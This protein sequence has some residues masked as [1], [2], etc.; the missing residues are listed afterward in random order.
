MP[1]PSSGHRWSQID[2]A[3]KTHQVVRQWCLDWI[4]REASRQHNAPTTNLHLYLAECTHEIIA[5]PL[6]PITV[7]VLHGNV[8]LCHYTPDWFLLAIRTHKCWST[9]T[10][11]AH[12]SLNTFGDTNRHLLVHR[13]YFYPMPDKETT[14]GQQIGNDY[15]PKPELVIKE[16]IFKLLTFSSKP[17]N[18][19]SISETL[20]EVRL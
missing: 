2:V 3:Y 6:M 5:S 17:A 20:Q 9:A 11:G 7:S 13:Q 15:T 14:Q 16:I 12:I 19:A 4:D 8:H 18:P 10:G 1:L